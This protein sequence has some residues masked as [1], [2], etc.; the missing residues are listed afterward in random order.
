MIYTEINIT[1]LEEIKAR[2]R[3]LADLTERMHVALGKLE[4]CKIMSTEQKK[5]HVISRNSAVSAV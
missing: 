5:G 2:V 1:G 4:N 3:E